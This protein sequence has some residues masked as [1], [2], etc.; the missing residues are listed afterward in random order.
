MF[1]KSFRTAVADK[2]L[3]EIKKAINIDKI[4]GPDGYKELDK[5]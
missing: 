1:N 3:R 5:K 4:E 2:M